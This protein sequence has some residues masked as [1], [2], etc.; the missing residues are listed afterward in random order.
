L[1]AEPQ[2]PAKAA[3]TIAW[4]TGAKVY[5]LD[6]VSTGPMNDLDYYITVMEN[7]LAVMQDALQ[8]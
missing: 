4:E 8:L 7:N 3:Q 2:Y 1:F 6:P 5:I